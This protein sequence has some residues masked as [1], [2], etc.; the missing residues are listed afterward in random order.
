MWY[1]QHNTHITSCTAVWHFT[2]SFSSPRKPPSRLVTDF[3]SLWIQC[4]VLRRTTH[5]HALPQLPVVTSDT[6]SHKKSS[7]AMNFKTLLVCNTQCIFKMLKNVKFSFRTKD[8]LKY[9]MS[10]HYIRS[11]GNF[12]FQQV[13]AK[14]KRNIYLDALKEKPYSDSDNITVV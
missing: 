8:H 13:E 9:L 10:F 6:V 2:V 12:V 4:H 14:P 11:L 5:C 7:T 1:I 3:S